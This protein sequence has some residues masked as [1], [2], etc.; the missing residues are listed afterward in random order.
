[1]RVY[2]KNVWDNDYTEVAL[3][4]LQECLNYEINT[5]YLI[6]DIDDKVIYITRKCNELLWYKEED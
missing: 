2:V 3:E 6:D 4:E 5:D 1:M